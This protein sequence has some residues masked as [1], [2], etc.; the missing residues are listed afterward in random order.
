VVN[1]ELVVSL[2]QDTRC[3]SERLEGR[4]RFMKTPCAVS[5]G[6]MITGLAGP[7]TSVVEPV[8][9]QLLS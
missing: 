2:A 4:A 1:D 3:G 8:H 5:P 7:F 9:A 6:N